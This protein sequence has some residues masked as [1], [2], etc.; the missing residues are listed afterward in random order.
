MGMVFVLQSFEVLLG[1]GERL[2]GLQV[3]H[4]QLVELMV[5]LIGHL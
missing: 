4:E 1:V 2:D 5:L 3:G